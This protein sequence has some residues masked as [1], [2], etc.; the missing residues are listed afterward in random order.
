MG[1][2]VN[3]DSVSAKLDVCTDRKIKRSTCFS[4]SILSFNP[5]PDQPLRVQF[6]ESD[7]WPQLS[8]LRADWFLPGVHG[9]SVYWSRPWWRSGGHLRWFDFAHT[10]FRHFLGGPSTFRKLHHWLHAAGS[11]DNKQPWQ[12]YLNQSLNEPLKKPL[13]ETRVS[14]KADG[15][16][17][18]ILRGFSMWLLSKLPSASKI[19]VAAWLLCFI[20]FSSLCIF[21][22]V[23][24]E[25]AVWK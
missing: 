19:K 12:F 25:G 2:T 14:H 11:F 5:S 18:A 10:K 8:S 13:N 21:R 17:E 23:T 15:I 9:A 24:A 4:C 22:P 7:L 20:L 3:K 6:P 16:S 1:A